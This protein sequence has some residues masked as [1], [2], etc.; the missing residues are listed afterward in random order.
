MAMIYA[1]I[2][3]AGYG[4]VLGPMVVARSVFRL[5]DQAPPAGRFGGPA[6]MWDALKDGVCKTATE[7]R[8]TGKVA[9]NDSK[10]LHTKAAGLRHLEAGVLGFGD[11]VAG[12]NPQMQANE[13]EHVG[14]WL[15]AA[16][17]GPTAMP[18]YAASD[19]HPWAAL[20][21]AVTA[22]E[23]AIGRNML[24][25]CCEQAGVEIIERPAAAVV[26]EDVFNQ[27]VAVMRSKAALS[28]G[29]VTQHLDHVWRM[30]D[31][32]PAFVAVDR[33]GGRTRYRELLAD[34]FTGQ[35]TGGEMT[36]LEETDS[37]SAY[38]L[39]AGERVMTVVFEVSAEDKH[40][41]VA[42]ASMTAKYA[43]ELMMA[44]LN[45]WFMQRIEGLVP[46]A[47]YA[48]DGN[49]FLRDV[50]PHLGRLGVDARMLRRAV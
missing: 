12:T 37:C 14:Q 43:R 15:D 29:H 42:L 19:E 11:L 36:V 30:C 3:E 40:L 23:L 35:T 6:C 39:E 28:F 44:R 4:P 21:V 33:Q 7:R 47:G 20:P 48:T 41:P 2:D 17:G 18:W 50:G 8:K 5:H 24:R 9:V 25:R 32:A 27:R 13:L 31:G 46:T 38:R 1:G 49:R 22:G 34:A 26:F 45:A 10:K 16:G